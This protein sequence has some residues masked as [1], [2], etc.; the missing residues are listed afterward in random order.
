MTGDKYY[1]KKFIKDN[2]TYWRDADGTF[3]IN[4]PKQL[5][6]RT[7]S[8]DESANSDSE[9]EAIARFIAN[10]PE[11]LRENLDF[12]NRMLNC[13]KLPDNYI[14]YY[15]ARIIQVLRKI[16][17]D[18]DPFKSEAKLTDT[19][20]PEM[21]DLLTPMQIQNDMDAVN[22]ESLAVILEW[23]SSAIKLSNGSGVRLFAKSVGEARS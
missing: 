15:A 10:M 6:A 8:E 19:N 23:L 3:T 1:M 2:W 16:D 17:T 13:S 11:L 18:F 14:T 7:F 12:V 4:A 5:I 20:K 9:N 21:K 22:V